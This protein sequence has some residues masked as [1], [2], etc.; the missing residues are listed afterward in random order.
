M[1]L[2]GVT[3]SPVV[4]S[5]LLAAGSGAAWALFPGNAADR[6]SA[7]APAM[8]ALRRRDTSRGV[9][10]DGTMS[11]GR[12]ISMP[13]DL[14]PAGAADIKIRL[15]SRKKKTAPLTVL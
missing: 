15:V 5:G 6:P 12:R 10:S 13:V 11:D 9:I 4:E 2:R 8:N 1:S 14:V 3:G 7:A